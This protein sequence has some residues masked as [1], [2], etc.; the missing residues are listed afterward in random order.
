MDGQPVFPHWGVWA[1]HNNAYVSS[2]NAITVDRSSWQLVNLKW[3]WQ[4]SWWGLSNLSNWE[5]GYILRSPSDWWIEKSVFAESDL[6]F[7]T[8]KHCK[9]KAWKLSKWA[10]TLQQPPYCPSNG[11]FTTM[12]ILNYLKSHTEA[13]TKVG[14]TL[15]NPFSVDTLDLLIMLR[16][17]HIVCRCTKCE[18]MSTAAHM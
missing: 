12:Q 18:D 16:N 10:E 3:M 14:L 13:H 6:N 5:G 2:A 1:S 4:E 9:T 11:I 15:T 8:G 17:K 7:E